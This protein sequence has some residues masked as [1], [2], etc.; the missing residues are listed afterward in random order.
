MSKDDDIPAAINRLLRAETNNFAELLCVAGLDPARDLAYANLAGV[1][2]ENLDL[3][4]YNLRGANLAG[5]SFKR[6]KIADADL[7]DAIYDDTALL[8]AAD[9][10]KFAVRKYSLTPLINS[11]SNSLSSG[12]NLEQRARVRKNSVKANSRYSNA[13]IVDALS[14]L[15]REDSARL[16]IAS[17]YYAVRSG[18]EAEELRQ[19]AYQRLLKSSCKRSFTVLDALLGIVRSEASGWDAKGRNRQEPIEDIELL[20]REK[21]ARL[22]IWMVD[23]ETPEEA[24]IQKQREDEAKQ[25]FEQLRRLFSHRPSVL[26]LLEGM[27]MGLSGGELRDFAGLNKLQ[28]NVNQKALMRGIAQLTANRWT[29]A[30]S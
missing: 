30:I 10:D 17:V 21:I 6:A 3:T 7:T 2:F 15:T 19:R 4:A 29:R 16:A 8:E 20:A 26:R 11:D 12:P 9:W 14:H 24:L 25:L 23:P 5:C 28:M 27:L 1:S 18:I 22:P 13:E